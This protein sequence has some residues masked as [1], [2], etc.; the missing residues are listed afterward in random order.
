MTPGALGWNPHPHGLS[1]FDS[2]EH[3]GK[4]SMRST[5]RSH[6][7]ANERCM[8]LALSRP[9]DLPSPRVSDGTRVLVLSARGNVGWC[10]ADTLHWE[11][12]A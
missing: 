11:T 12:D 7:A 1:L 9:T 6:L 2:P 10:W 3:L 8:L 4:M 5:A